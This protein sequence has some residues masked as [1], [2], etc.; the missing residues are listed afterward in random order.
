MTLVP[1]VESRDTQKIYEELSKKIRHLI[2]SI[3]NNSDNCDEKYMTIKFISH[4][5]LPLRKC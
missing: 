2:T 1:T 3:T 5:D 4:D